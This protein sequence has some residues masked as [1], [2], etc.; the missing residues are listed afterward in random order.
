MKTNV[1]ILSLNDNPLK[2]TLGDSISIP[3]VQS[4]VI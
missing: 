4:F 2:S 3:N 1:N